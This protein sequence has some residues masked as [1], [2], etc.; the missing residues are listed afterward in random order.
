MKYL[1]FIMLLLLMSIAQEGVAQRRGFIGGIGFGISTNTY[2]KR[3]ATVTKTAFVTNIR[4]GYAP[5]EQ[6]EIYYSGRTSWGVDVVKSTLLGLS[7]LS[8]SYY[9]QPAAPT[10]YLTGG[11][12]WAHW[13]GLE[14]KWSDGVGVVVGGG[15]EVAKHLSFD[16]GLIYSALF[17]VN[18]A[19]SVSF[20]VNWLAY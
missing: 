16:L 8:A 18:N 19:F 6:L 4:L 17:D 13:N 12:G 20:T 9:L 2:K 11:F 1:S 15:Y 14:T 3:T 5:S 10:L 7:S